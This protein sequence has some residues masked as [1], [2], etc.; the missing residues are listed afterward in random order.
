MRSK[1]DP[2]LKDTIIKMCKDIMFDF[3]ETG[4]QVDFLEFKRV[5]QFVPVYQ[6]I[7]LYAQ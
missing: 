5:M 7:P 3:D 6:E 2:V 4:G 1:L